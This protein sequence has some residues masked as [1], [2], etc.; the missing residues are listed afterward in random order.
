M[1]T[2]TDVW[3]SSHPSSAEL[4]RHAAQRSAVA[5]AVAEPRHRP[6]SRITGRLRSWRLPRWATIRPVDR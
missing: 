4:S 3:W 2:S 1:I 5:Q 6:S